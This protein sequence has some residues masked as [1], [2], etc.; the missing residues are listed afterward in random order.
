MA[1]VTPA[2][3]DTSAIS[4]E[5]KVMNFINMKQSSATLMQIIIFLFD[6][7]IEHKATVTFFFCQEKWCK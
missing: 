6:L 5:N 1:P 3:T 7:S 4:S 2:L